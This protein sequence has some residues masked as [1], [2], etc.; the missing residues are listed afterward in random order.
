VLWY[1]IYITQSA[2]ARAGAGKRAHSSAALCF[3]SALF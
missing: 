2:G 1:M 3:F